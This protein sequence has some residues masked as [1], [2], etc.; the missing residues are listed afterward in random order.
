MNSPNIVVGVA[1]LY[2]FALII[3]AGGCVLMRHC[4]TLGVLRE[5]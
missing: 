3:I 5:P 1:H 4:S 2:E